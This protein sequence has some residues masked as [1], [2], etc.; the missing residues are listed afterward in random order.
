MGQPPLRC[1]GGG[2][3][4]HLMTIP[5]RGKNFLGARFT[6]R[7]LGHRVRARI[8]MLTTVGGNST[9]CPDP[10]ASWNQVQKGAS[11]EINVDVR[12]PARVAEERPRRFRSG[13]R[14]A[15]DWQHSEKTATVYRDGSLET[16]VVATDQTHALLQLP[17]HR[18]SPL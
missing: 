3:I 7:L 16:V 5:G 6:C 12:D 15:I 14:V 1:I 11:M 18:L 10:R 2:D 4:G 9:R 17:R 13:E 8:G